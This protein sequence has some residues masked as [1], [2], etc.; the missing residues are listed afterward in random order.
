M[1]TLHSAPIVAAAFLLLLALAANVSRLR[2]VKGVSLGDGGHKGLHKAIRA[3]ANALEYTVPFMGLLVVWELSGA[4]QTEV[5]LAG[6]AFLFVRL[7]HAWGMLGRGRFML[8]R[9]GAALT[10]LLG[11]GLVVGVLVSSFR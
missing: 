10:Y 6:A 1:A 3:H 2:M 8:R 5:L 9:A 11:V 4:G 7:I